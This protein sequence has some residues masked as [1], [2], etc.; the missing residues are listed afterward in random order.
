MPRRPAKTSPPPPA[1]RSWVWRYRRLL[2]L[3]VL[4]GFTAQAGA[5]YMLV[6]V[7]LPP[8]QV[9]AQTTF[10]Y[11]ANGVQLAA[12]NG[13]VN[14]V[15]VPLEAVPKVLVNAVVATEDK[16]FFKHGG[17]DP[18]GIIRAT[19]ADLRGHS[20]QG[21]STLTQQYV[22]NVYLGQ[23]RTFS[24]KVKEASLAVKLER[25]LTKRQILE[26]YLNTIYFGRGAY[27]VQAA[28]RAYFGKDVGQIGLPEASY[29]AAIIKSPGTADPSRDPVGADAR[30]DSTLLRM[31]RAGY[32]TAAD[33]AAVSATRVS[34]MAVDQ[35]RAEPT[36]TDP[37]VGTQYFSE[38]VRKQLTD[39]LH[40]SDATVFGGGL[41]VKTTLDLGIQRQAYQAVYGVLN[42]P[43]DP[44]GALVA[45]DEDGSVRAMVGGRDWGQSKVNLAVGREGGGAGRQAGSTFKPFLLAEIVKEG[46]TV[47]STFPAPAKAIFPKADNGADY[48]VTNFEDESFD[49]DLNLIDA[50]KSSVNT[51][52]AQ[53]AQ[54]IGPQH[55]VDMAHQLGVRADLEPNLSLVLG[56]NEVSVLDMAGA[57]STFARR[58]DHVDPVTILEVSKDDHV[59]YRAHPTRTR[60]LTTRQA[61]IVNHCLQQVVQS[62]TGV[63]AQFGKPMAGKTGTTEDFGDAWFIGYTPKLTAAVWM[64]YPQGA[65]VKKLVNLH[66]QRG[67]VQGGSLPAAIFKRFMTAVE[68]GRN[69]GSFFDATSFPGKILRDT[70]TVKLATTTTSTTAPPS[71]TTSTAPGPTTTVPGTTTTAKPATTT[72]STTAKPATTTSTTAKPA[73]AAP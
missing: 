56:T 8:E 44:A 62:G 28:S 66:G 27:G 50:T 54:A 30:R 43:N 5:A 70:G 47:N 3:V 61:D 12:F 40:I 22:K 35:A 51:V 73:G 36:F 46:F 60:V 41:R 29:L 42:Q 67:G 4:L 2:F 26:R 64:G 33:R 52:Y 7:P 34:D 19:L 18:V 16:G 37:D 48:T 39:V 72:T 21:G 20:L 17:V 69:D 63:N 11:D 45:V 15:S 57:Y 38:Y 53:A 68:Q 59:I 58:G 25:K 14:R 32:I 9:Q 10:L 13:G 49:H 24:R 71:T 23:E 1:R 65:S 6:R 55:L 31:Q